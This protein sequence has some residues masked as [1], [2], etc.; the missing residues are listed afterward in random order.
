MA[1]LDE[2]RVRQALLAAKILSFS[3]DLVALQSCR[4]EDELYGL[5]IKAIEGEPFLMSRVVRS[6]NSAAFAGRGGYAVGASECL[7][8]IGLGGAK[9]IAE[10]F[11]IDQ[12]LGRIVRA[13]RFSRSVWREARLVGQ[14][15]RLF[16]SSCEQP[17]DYSG[18]GLPAIM[19]F[20]G[21]LFVMSLVKSE[22]EIPPMGLPPESESQID[23]ISLA[24]SVLDQLKLPELIGH[25]VS[26]MARLGSPERPPFAQSAAAVLLSRV[27][28]KNV[29]VAQSFS[30]DVAESAV[31]QACALIGIGLGHLDGMRSEVQQVLRSV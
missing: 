23:V 7:L 29:D 11:L 14:V 17:F 5:L 19:S 27:L 21:E 3:S 10:D 4:D 12:A 30:A 22:Y 16:R 25:T 8:R 31:D 15:S 26:S 2:S 18:P 20:L 28:V 6:A 1:V 9:Q 24:V 13:N